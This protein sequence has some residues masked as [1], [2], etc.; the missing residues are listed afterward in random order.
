V[1]VSLVHIE[2]IYSHFRYISAVTIY[3]FYFRYIS[4]VTICVL[5]HT[6]EIEDGMFTLVK[7]FNL[8]RRK[9]AENAKDVAR[10]TLEAAKEGRFI[11][12]AL[13]PG[14]FLYTL[15]RG[16]LPADSFS[17]AFL[18]LILYVPFRVLSFIIASLTPAVL[19]YVH[20]RYYTDDNKK[21][22]KVG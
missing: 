20:K 12:T 2:C 15:S 16:V 10:Y 6:D 13:F 17:T 4:A 19:R 1:K 8:Y 3:V 7:I 5:F 11:T 14:V 9:R 22:E 18:E 21:L